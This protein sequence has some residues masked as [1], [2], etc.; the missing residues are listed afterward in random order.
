[1]LS[2][3]CSEDTRQPK[4]DNIQQ[5]CRHQSTVDM[6]QTADDRKQSKRVVAVC[7]H[8]FFVFQMIIVKETH[9]SLQ[10][11]TE[12]WVQYCSARKLKKTKEKNG[13]SIYVLSIY[14]GITC[15][16]IC[17]AVLCRCACASLCLCLCLCLYLCLCL[18]LCLCKEGEESNTALCCFSCLL[19]SAPVLGPAAPPR[20]YSWLYYG[21]KS[22]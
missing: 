16:N 3:F 4:T 5:T 12:T 18:C 9:V 20:S 14:H 8:R 15:Q 7:C 21:M 22:L 2:S 1:V 13:C 6:S 17:H 10:I 19:L 11:K